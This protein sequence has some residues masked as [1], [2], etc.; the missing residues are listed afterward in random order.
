MV[1]P[2]IISLIHCH[3]VEYKR[4]E[5]V[6]EAN[7]STVSCGSVILY[8]GTNSILFLTYGRAR[9][10]VNTHFLEFINMLQN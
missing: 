4:L 8:Q 3:P 1:E 6:K 9:V 5:I 2:Y 7:D 10:E